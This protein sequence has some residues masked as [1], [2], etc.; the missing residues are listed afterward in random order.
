[1]GERIKGNH[2]QKDRERRGGG[3]KRK[4]QEKERQSS[5]QIVRQNKDRERENMEG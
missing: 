2:R 3:S 5:R 4:S 1:M